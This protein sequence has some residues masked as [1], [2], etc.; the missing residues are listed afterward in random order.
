MLTFTPEAVSMPRSQPAPASATLFSITRPIPRSA[1][2][3]FLAH[4]AG[5]S[6]MFWHDPV[7]QVTH[8]GLGLAWSAQASGDNR[9][10]TIRMAA[11]RLFAGALFDRDAPDFTA[12]RVFGGF[13]FSDQHVAAGVW[14]AFPAA[15]FMLP[16][17]QLSAAGEQTWLTLNRIAHTDSDI[18]RFWNTL[19]TEF[20][21]LE[22]LLSSTLS[23]GE[24]PMLNM[25]RFPLSED[26]WSAMIARATGEMRA[27]RLVKVVLA[28]TSEAVFDRPVDPLRALGRL[29]RHYPDTYR[30][31]IEPTAGQAFFGATPELLIRTTGQKLWTAAVAG[32]RRRGLTP[33]EDAAL[34]RELMGSDK[35]R[36]EHQIVVSMLRERLTPLTESIRMPDTPSVIKLSNI[37]HL[38]TPVSAVLSH[39]TSIF[40]LVEQLHPT[41]ALGGSPREAALS[42]IDQLE[43]I[44]R[45]WYAAPVGWV[46]AHGDG[47]FSVAIRS[48]VSKGS[49]ARLYA[50]AGIVA[51][52]AA[53]KEWDET[54]VKFKPLMDALMATEGAR[55]GRPQ[56]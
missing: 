20:D 25:L 5:K 44:G 9:F 18:D 23:K 39:S 52:S 45:G 26:N 49:R 47:L 53:D 37:Q 33:T 40:D 43:E 6:R 51:D 7:H 22:E 19:D 34:E 15:C 8:A 2:L 10:A 30:F 3:N 21:R 1:P 41:P 36:H 28:R 11:E 35:E 29:E 31:L 13:A 16:E 27:G 42:L 56:S 50:G 12:P 24:M 48:A 55:D 46:S 32:S 17:I 4:G 38:Y 54:A 14:S